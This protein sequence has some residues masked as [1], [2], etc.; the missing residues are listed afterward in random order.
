[1]E[2]KH[3]PIEVKSTLE[4]CWGLLSDQPRSIARTIG[5]TFI[6]NLGVKG[7]KVYN[8]TEEHHALA[9]AFREHSPYFD[10]ARDGNVVTYTGNC[11]FGSWNE[12]EAKV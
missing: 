12:K 9:A 7:S 3:L 8:Y 2:W 11:M 1:M 6:V 5:E 10:I 4:L